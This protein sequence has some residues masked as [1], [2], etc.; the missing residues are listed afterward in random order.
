MA[1]IEKGRLRANGLNFAVLAA[2]PRKGP[3]ALLLHGFPEGKESWLPQLDALARAG[4]RAVAPDLRGYGESDAPKGVEQYSLAKLNDDVEG[5]IDA[6]A[7]ERVDLVGHDWGAIIG[8]SFASRFPDR[9]R[10]WSALS[11]GHPDLFTQAD[12][13]QRRR[14]SYIQL[15]FQAP[16][17]EE[18]LLEDGARRLQAMYR[19]GPNPNA[20]SGEQV[21][22]FVAGFERPGRL[23][24]GLNYYRANLKAAALQA[25]PPAPEPIRCPT[26]LIWGEQDPA[27]GRR[28]AELTGGLVAGP[29]RLVA[30]AGA[31]HW[32]QFEKPDEVSR[33]IVEHVKQYAGE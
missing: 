14:S 15:F 3:V 33:L 22:D 19:L 5:L 24:A 32:L 7:E 26:Q 23:T 31:G 10:S 18:V 2:G 16:K 20:I 12:E 6:L 17:A 1:N 11:V 8:W 13:E 27:L 21:G 30:L 25:Y 28:Q 9:V 29:Y 4:W